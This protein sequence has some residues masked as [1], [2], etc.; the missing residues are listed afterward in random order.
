MSEYV[1]LFRPSGAH[2]WMRCAQWENS[3]SSSIWSDEGV[4]LHD[5]VLQLLT[6]ETAAL[7]SQELTSE[8]ADAVRFC[9]SAVN[10]IPG[11]TRWYE[12]KWTLRPITGETRAQGTADAVIWDDDRNTLTI[13]DYKFG[14]AVVDA[15][16]NLQ[17]MLYAAAVMADVE[18]DGL[19]HI[20]LVIVQPRLERVSTWR[21]TPERLEQFCVEVDR[22]VSNYG[23]Q[24]ATPGQVQCKWCLH[25]GVCEAQTNMVLANVTD[26][27]A[28]LNAAD[29][30]A[31]KIEAAIERVATMDNAQLATVYGILDLIDNWSDKIKQAMLERLLQGESVP[32]HKLVQ[33]RSGNRAWVD[34]GQ[35]LE[36]LRQAHLHDDDVI[37]QKLISPTKASKLLSVGQRKELDALVTRSEGKPTVAKID[38][39]RPELGADTLFLKEK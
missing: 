11:R 26:D 36:F 7:W 5:R 23:D 9:A 37:E 10:Q 32:G 2:G 8:Q 30:L 27:F 4:M 31:T 33:G 16:E 20:D 3:P 34:E 6:L 38:D 35:A 12:Q 39:K 21:T 14:Y 13:I 19:V 25:A 18:L 28:D 22:A 29:A 24:P 17:L 15:M 1:A